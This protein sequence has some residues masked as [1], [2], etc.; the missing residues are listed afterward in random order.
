MPEVFANQQ[1]ELLPRDLRQV[2]AFSRAEEAALLEDAIGREVELPM[3]VE[4]L[5][6]PEQDGAVVEDSLAVLFHQADD[7][8]HFAARLRQPL[9]LL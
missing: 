6:R 3:D 2:E 4:D 7:D 1:A 9:D 8:R 5:T